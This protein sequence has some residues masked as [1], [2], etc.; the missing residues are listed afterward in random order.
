MSKMRL[1]VWD[2]V[3]R[4]YTAGIAFAIAPDAE[5]ARKQII[6]EKPW[7]KSDIGVEP[8]VYRVDRRVCRAVSGG[9]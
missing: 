6:A 9:G 2:N 7:A 1:Y 8:K 3:L 5:D 4:D